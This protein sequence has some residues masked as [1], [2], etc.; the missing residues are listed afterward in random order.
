MKHKIYIPRSLCVVFD[1]V[2][3]A[4]WSLFFRVAG[5][6]ALKTDTHTLYVLYGAPTLSIEKVEAY[7]SVG[8]DVWVPWDRMCVVFYED[9]FWC[10]KMQCVSIDI[11][12][13]RDTA[14]QAT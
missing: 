9:Y 12:R 10:L 6:H 2:V 11:E 4:R 13:N 7:D 14:R 3:I 8:V 5:Q 1:K